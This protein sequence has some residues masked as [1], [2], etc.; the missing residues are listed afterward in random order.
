MS[1]KIILK[2]LKCLNTIYHPESKL[3]F[4]SATDKDRVVV[5]VFD[6]DTETLI[7][8]D[9]ESIKLCEYWKFKY[10][11]PEDEEE[12]EE[13][14]GE[15]EQQEVEEVVEQQSPPES[16]EECVHVKV[17][18]QEQ[19]SEAQAHATDMLTESFSQLIKNVNQIEISYQKKIHELEV[20]LK[21]KSIDYDD[22]TSKHDKL[23]QKFDSIKNLFS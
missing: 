10:E 5:G 7:P 14:E 6:E 9:S 2:K 13:E 11:I 8:L 1:S 22:I 18:V 23:K 20:A 19:N 21:Q 4:K 17:Q 12:G 16:V 15:S 3:V